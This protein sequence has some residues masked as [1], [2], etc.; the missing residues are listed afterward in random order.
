MSNPF[1]LFT[2]DSHSVLARAKSLAK[3]QGQEVITPNHLLFGILDLSGCQAEQVLARFPFKLSNL[4]PHVLALSKLEAKE[5]DNDIEIGYKDWR[6]KLS[7]ESAAILDAANAEAKEND[8][9]FVDTRLLIL[10]ILRHG[11]NSAAQLL[12]Q[13]DL[14]LEAF[15]TEARLSK[16]PPVNLPRFELPDKSLW[17]PIQISPVFWGL[18]AWTV[19]FG[20]L[21]YAGIGNPSASA[22]FFILGGT[23]VSVALHEFGH[24]LVAYLGGDETVV[25]KGYLTLNPLNYAHPILSIV[26]PIIFLLMGGLPLPGGAVYINRLLIRNRNMRSLMSGAGPIATLLCIIVLAIPFMLGWHLQFFTHDDF[27]KVLA[28]LLLVQLGALFL[29]LL[30]IPGLD[31]FGIIEPFLERNLAEKLNLL[32][33]MIFLLLFFL[34]FRTELLTYLLWQP[35]FKLLGM[36]A[37]ELPYL[38]WEGLQLCFPWMG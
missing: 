38:A 15:R 7:V 12:E 34:F 23:T 20:G 16:T 1:V 8:L 37:P 10:G 35:V 36:L 32:R 24:A 28:A 3:R 26:F 33:P 6:R 25:H 5:T 30:P 31:G 13:Y 29:N 17:P 9:K 2:R 11:D 27:W 4:K 14:S 21:I 18:V 19:F 22:I